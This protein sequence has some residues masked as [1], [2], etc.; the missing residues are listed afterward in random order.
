MAT[1]RKNFI[2]RTC[3]EMDKTYVDIFKHRE[4]NKELSELLMECIPIKIDKS[5]GLPIYMCTDCTE[6]LC[7]VWHFKSMVLY[8]ALKFQRTLIVQKN[9]VMMQ[10]TQLPLT[11]ASN[12]NEKNNLSVNQEKQHVSSELIIKDEIVIKNEDTDSSLAVDIAQKNNST[13]QIEEVT[14]NETEF[15]KLEDRNELSQSILSSNIGENKD[16][17]E[18]NN[19]VVEPNTED[20]DSNSRDYIKTLVDKECDNNKNF[21]DKKNLKYCNDETKKESCNDQPEKCIHVRTHNK[22]SRYMCELCGKSFSD[23]SSFSAHKATHRATDKTYPCSVCG[24]VFA[25]QSNVR[26]HQKRHA[27]VKPH[28]CTHCGKAFGESATLK[29]HSLVHTGEKPHSCNICG[30]KFRQKGCLPKHMRIHTGETPFPCELCPSKFKYKHHLQIHMKVH[31][32]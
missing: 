10:D 1:I 30:K 4:R 23:Y 13:N 9:C 3:M 7:D 5:D 17:W 11:S 29:V 18:E 21:S 31:K 2:C 22:Q 25:T 19:D 12:T 27:Q 32:S 15:S 8:S 28:V 14:S 6:K 24:K 20:S 26:T 16:L